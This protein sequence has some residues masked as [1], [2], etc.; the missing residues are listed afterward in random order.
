MSS[1]FQAMTPVGLGRFDEQIRQN[2]ALFDR[3][4]HMFSPFAARS[5]EADPAPP[6]AGETTTPAAGGDTLSELK[7][8]MEAMQRQ[9]A[10]LESRK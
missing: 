3:A 6:A 8:Q 4:M 7:Q 10:A 1:Q 2:I 9:L 5:D